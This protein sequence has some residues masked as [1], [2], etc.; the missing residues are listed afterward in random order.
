MKTGIPLSIPLQRLVYR[1]PRQLKNAHCLFN[2]LLHISPL[3]RSR[4]WAHIILPHEMG[5]AVIFVHGVDPFEFK[6]RI[7]VGEKVQRFFLF[8]ETVAVQYTSESCKPRCFVF[9]SFQPTPLEVQGA[10]GD[11]FEVAHH[12][13]TRHP[14]I[15]RE[16]APEL[17]LSSK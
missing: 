3:G 2:S 1:E 4:P 15:I 9:P 11:Y 10:S 17:R 12:K 7:P 13:T 14:F 8:R 6:F 5:N 16:M